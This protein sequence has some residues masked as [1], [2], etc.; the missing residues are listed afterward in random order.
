MPSPNVN[1]ARVR[2]GE[3]PFDKGGHPRC[4][5]R[6][7]GEKAGALDTLKGFAAPN[8]SP[9]PNRDKRAG[10]AAA[11][12]ATGK[13]S[14]DAHA[15]FLSFSSTKASA[16]RN[17]ARQARTMAGALLGR[18]ERIVDDGLTI[19]R[20]VMVKEAIHPTDLKRFR[21]ILWDKARPHRTSLFETFD[22]DGRL[23]DGRVPIYQ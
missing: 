20:N 10:G 14:P 8:R 1:R 18:T 11:Q 19:P 9:R 6:G 23:E 4:S 21:G 22:E 12:S 17:L 13:S 16:R 2:L 15:R 3:Y 5:A 7:R